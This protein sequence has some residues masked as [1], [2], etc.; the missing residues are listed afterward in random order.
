MR[1]FIIF[2]F[3]KFEKV[4]QIYG[5]DSWQLM[6]WENFVCPWKLMQKVAVSQ[7]RCLCF[8]MQFYENKSMILK[9]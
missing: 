3:E 2:F 5:S 8:Y 9:K 1:K 6:K 4:W 7:K